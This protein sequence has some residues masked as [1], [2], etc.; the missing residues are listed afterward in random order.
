MGHVCRS[1]MACC[2]MARAAPCGHTTL[3]GTGR[4]AEGN[5][6]IWGHGFLLFYRGTRS[7]YLDGDMCDDKAMACCSSFG[8]SA[9]CSAPIPMAQIR[10]K[11]AHAGGCSWIFGHAKIAD[12]L[13]FYGQRTARCS[14]PIPMAQIRAKLL[15]TPDECAHDPWSCKDRR[16]PAVLWKVSARFALFRTDPDGTKAAGDGAILPMTMRSA[17]LATGRMCTDPDTNQKLF[18]RQ[19]VAPM[20]RSDGLLSDH[21]VQGNRQMRQCGG[22]IDRSGPCQPQADADNVGTTCGLCGPVAGPFGRVSRGVRPKTISH[23]WSTR[24]AEFRA[25]GGKACKARP[26]PLRATP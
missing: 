4:N 9:R 26:M 16:W 25:G 17:V 6:D 21:G 5:D 24:V 7:H 14:A 2:S 18:Q 15:P 22:G 3:D 8:E 10:A 23:I 20:Q 13:L 12:G 1:Q 19:R 11:P